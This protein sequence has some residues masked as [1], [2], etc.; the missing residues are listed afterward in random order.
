MRTKLRDHEKSLFETRTHWLSM[1][2]PM[3]ILLAAAV[4]FYIAYFRMD[5]GGATPVL[6]KISLILFVLSVI[7]FVY[8]EM[9]RRR[10]I[11]VVTNLRVIDERGIFTLF[12]KE[13]PLEK[14]N[15]L[16][17]EQTIIGRMLNYGQVEIQTAAEDGATVYTL[18]TNPKRLKDEIAVAR[19]AYSRE[20]LKSSGGHTM[21][22]A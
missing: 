6:R 22:Q 5:P 16:S 11:W 14:I 7:F 8:R 9:Y 3:L 2:Q 10:D 21:S 19:D 12:T 13:S 17:Y 15:N 4:F 1:W 20:L 18:I